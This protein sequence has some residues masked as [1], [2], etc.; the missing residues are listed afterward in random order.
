MV[1]Q[2]SVDCIIKADGLSRF[3]KHELECKELLDCEVNVLVNN[4]FCRSNGQKKFQQTNE[5]ESRV[6]QAEHSSIGFIMQMPLT[7]A[8]ECTNV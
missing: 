7:P 6:R 2:S 1:V 5:L 3:S 8:T 4:D